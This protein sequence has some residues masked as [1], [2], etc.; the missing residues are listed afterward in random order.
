M[1]ED[2][3]TLAAAIA[4]RREKGPRQTPWRAIALAS[5]LVAV[6]IAFIVVGLVLTA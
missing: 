5:G 4:K 2:P 3:Y 6:C 1:R